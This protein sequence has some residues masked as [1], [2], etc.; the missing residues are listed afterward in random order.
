MF[1]RRL[2][3]KHG[4]TLNTLRLAA[5]LLCQG[6]S[7]DTPVSHTDV[8]NR[9]HPQEGMMSPPISSSLQVGASHSRPI[10][11]LFTPESLGQTHTLTRT[12]TDADLIGS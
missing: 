8:Y 7:F 4:L 2:P 11:G 6:L 9:L 10:G 3:A 12:P 1:A 5:P